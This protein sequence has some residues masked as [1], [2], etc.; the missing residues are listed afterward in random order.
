MSNK[1]VISKWLLVLLVILASSGTI[2]VA[3]FLATVR[4]SKATSLTF[5]QPKG[6]DANAEVTYKGNGVLT[7]LLGRNDA[8][9]YYEGELKSDGSNLR[10]CDFSG[11]RSVIKHKKETTTVKD[12]AVMIKPSNAASYKNTVDILGEMSINDVNRYA[13]ADIS[14]VEEKLINSR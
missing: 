11:I 1:V 12:F 2:S 5:Y 6:D 3:Y 13:M 9:G 4:A 8:V 14:R 7:I 10:I